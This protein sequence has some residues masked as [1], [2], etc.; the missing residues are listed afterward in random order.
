LS[1]GDAGVVVPPP[2]HALAAGELRV[3][4]DPLTKVV[5]WNAAIG[6]ASVS[7]PPDGD[8]T[9]LVTVG[10]S[11]LLAK[12]TSPARQVWVG[13]SQQ[14]WPK[15]PDFVVFWTNVLNWVAGDAVQWTAMP[16]Q[17]LSANWKAIASPPSNVQPNAWPGI[18]RNG[19]ALLAMN[20]DVPI[21]SS[22]ATAPLNL[23]LPPGTS[24]HSW[25]PYFLI[26]AIG[27]GIL[28]VATMPRRRGFHS[29]L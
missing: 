28:A 21:F 29:S 2:D 16:V 5:N 18:Y 6:G 10:N 15:S 1:A 19:E 8:W 7:K 3:T 9:P 4:P 13:F 11:V 22:D 26:A 12:R 23:H 17:Q 24:N 14:A 27:C 25:S 20:S